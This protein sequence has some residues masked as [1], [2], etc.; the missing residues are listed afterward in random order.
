VRLHVAFHPSLMAAGTQPPVPPTRPQVCVVVDVMRASTT[1]ITFLERG[2]SRI[3]VAS[4]VE[5][6]RAHAAAL[7]G[8]VLA[9]EQDGVAPPGFDYGNSPVEVSRAEIEGRAVIFVTTNGT[10]AIRAVQALGPVLVGALRNAA[11]VAD[12]AT[13][14]SRDEASDLTIVCAGREGAYGID[15]AYCAGA[16]TDRVLRREAFDLTDGAE[17]ALRLYRS[18][19]DAHALF[20]RAAAGRNII[21]LGLGPDVAYCAQS[22]AS[23]VV[24][25]LGRE[26]R[27]LD[28]GRA[29]G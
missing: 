4:S 8:A 1:L 27:M 20:T 12:E 9:G 19:P 3:Y 16:L 21:R 23:T 25:R 17:A 13:A 10:V 18:E 26:L 5:A 28:N 22:D 14:V 2:A 7:N 24:P 6:A 29:D 11:A 15:D